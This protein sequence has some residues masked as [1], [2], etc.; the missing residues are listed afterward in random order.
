MGAASDGGY[1]GSD[2]QAFFSAVVSG[3]AGVYV[4][5]LLEDAGIETGLIVRPGQRVSVSGD[6]SLLQTPR[7]GRGSFTVQQRGSLMLQSVA[8][9]D[10]LSVA[11]GGTAILIGCAG[12]MAGVIVTDSNF[13]ASTTTLG[14]SISLSNAQSVT[15]QDTTFADG[16]QLSVLGDTSLSLVSCSGQVTGVTV[17]DSSLSASTT[18][19]G[20]S[21]SLSNAQSV[22]LQDT[23]FADG[24]Q[25]SVLGGTYRSIETSR[26]H[27]TQDTVTDS[28]FS[29]DA[30]S[31]TT[32]GGSIS[33]SNAES[34][35]LQ[36]TTFAEGTRLN[37]LGDTSLSLD[38]VSMS[39]DVL[40]VAVD[41]CA[42][43]S[44]FQLSDMTVTTGHGAA[45]PQLQPGTLVVSRG[46]YGALTLNPPTT[47]VFDWFFP[48]RSLQSQSI[49]PL[50]P[51]KSFRMSIIL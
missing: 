32:L 38:G 4:V 15:L 36:D 18:T 46:A 39:F 28:W 35:T 22:T 40:I 50:A 9:S 7:W 16:T 44:Q 49:M 43:Q 20:G 51:S 48:V 33:L 11:R 12:P 30:A 29:M 1:L 37:V 21:I 19:L 17:T 8:V 13:S 6:A 42:R 47:S 27:H 2:S 24:T 25:L 41:G 5:V 3:A 10:S 31:T 45:W 26:W 34:V 23:T 14:D